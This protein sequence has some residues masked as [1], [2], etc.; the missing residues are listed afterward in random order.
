[1]PGGRVALSWSRTNPEAGIVKLS[2]VEKGGPRPEETSKQGF[3]SMVIRTVAAQLGSQARY[4]LLPSGVH[5]SIEGAI[6][7]V[8]GKGGHTT[9]AESTSDHMYGAGGSGGRPLRFF[10]VED[11]VLVGLKAKAELEDAGHK[12]V[13]FAT[14]TQQAMAL[15]KDLEFDIA[16]LDVRLGNENS[17]A[18]AENLLL[19]GM[20]VAFVTGFEDETVLPPFLHAIPR[21]QKPYD[22]DKILKFFQRS[23]EASPSSLEFN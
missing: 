18:I 13:A 3:G 9:E 10:L 19:R 22:V 4:D 20:K 17:I 7:G 14:N 16:L 15:L 21:F 11:E 6:E 1:V 8:S 2:W 23:E 12:V 5:F